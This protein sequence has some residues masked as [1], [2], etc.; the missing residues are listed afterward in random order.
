MD[1]CILAHPILGCP[2]IEILSFL[3]LF[4]KG[5]NTILE[6][7][8]GLQEEVARKETNNCLDL[9]ITFKLTL[10]TFELYFTTK[11]E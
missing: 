11:L 8:M 3:K 10:I 4:T 9:Y 5:H 7:V 2:N 6:K 1:G